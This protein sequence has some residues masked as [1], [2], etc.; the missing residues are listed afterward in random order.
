MGFLSFLKS[1]EKALDIVDK[2]TNGVIAGMDK[3]FFTNEEKS[4]A[5]L[6]VTEAHLKLVEATAGENSK[7]SITRR[8]LAVM[9]MGSFLALLLFG[10][11]I[12]RWDP[13]WSKH[14][15]VCA[16]A[17]STLSLTI[18][19]FYFGTYGIKSIFPNIGN[20]KKRK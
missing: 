11:V 17:L 2:G 4:E 10:A 8:I 18:G 6:K 9:I 16:S 12:H 15:L 19:I 7:R 1:S 3:L 13:E 5:S 14:V 20:G